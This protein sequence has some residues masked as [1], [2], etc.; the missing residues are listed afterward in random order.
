MN[1]AKITSIF[2]ALDMNDPKSAYKTWSKEWDKNAKKWKKD[3][4]CLVSQTLIKASIL[5]A[6]G[7]LKEA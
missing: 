4:P 5:S 2:D 1:N 3:I 6:Q 7:N